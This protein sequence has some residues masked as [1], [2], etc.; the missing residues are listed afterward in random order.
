MKLAS[1]QAKS[2]KFGAVSTT[3]IIYT[4]LKIAMSPWI[5]RSMKTQSFSRTLSFC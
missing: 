3:K 5:P 4:T 2:H 1:D